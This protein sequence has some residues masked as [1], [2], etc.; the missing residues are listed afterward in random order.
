MV[1]GTLELPVPPLPSCP[2]LLSP[3]HFTTPLF[4]TAHEFSPPAA[5]ATTPVS[6]PRSTGTGF[7]L[8]SYDLSP[9][10]PR[11]LFPQHRTPVPGT[12]AHVWSPPAATRATPLSSP[13]T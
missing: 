7:A 11:K 10:S 1:T 8:S 6:T 12:Y 13:M 9:S 5:R 4:R 2:N 3:Q